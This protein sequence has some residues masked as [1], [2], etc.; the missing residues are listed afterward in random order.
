MDRIASVRADPPAGPP[1]ADAPAGPGSGGSE[2]GAARSRDVDEGGSAA[3]LAAAL[4]EGSPRVASA[5]PGLCR[6]DARGW[7]RREGGEAELG[8]RLRDAARA[9]GFGRVGVGVA[10]AAVS[11]DAS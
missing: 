11:A 10:G 4:L 5:G 9:A 2:G 8:R 7:R 3:R 6:A 1:A